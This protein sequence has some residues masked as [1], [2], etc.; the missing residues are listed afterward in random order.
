MSEVR[1]NVAAMR[2]AYETP[3][4][5]SLRGVFQLA[6]EVDSGDW[7]CFFPISKRA[8]GMGRYASLEAAP[9]PSADAPEGAS[10]RYPTPWTV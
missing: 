5:P 8:E 7:R 2:V 4:R 10:K 9:S 6:R 1:A 3:E